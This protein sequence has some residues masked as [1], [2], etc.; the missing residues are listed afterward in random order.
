MQSS[1]LGSITATRSAKDMVRVHMYTDHPTQ[2]QPPDVG[3][4]KSEAEHSPH[5]QLKT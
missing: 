1:Y 5:Q 4:G 2:A 3:G